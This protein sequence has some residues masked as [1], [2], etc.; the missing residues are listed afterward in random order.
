MSLEIGSA[1]FFY[2]GLQSRKK[3]SQNIATLSQFGAYICKACMQRRAVVGQNLSLV[4]TLTWDLRARISSLLA[5][6]FRLGAFGLMGGSGKLQYSLSL[7]PPK[8]I[9]KPLRV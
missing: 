2:P 4:S 1:H 9:I 7:D 6:L 8:S 3:K 5:E